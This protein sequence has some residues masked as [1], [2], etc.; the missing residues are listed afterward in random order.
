MSEH[1]MK[2]CKVCY[3]IMGQC[4]CPSKD[5]RIIWDLCED[6]KKDIEKTKNTHNFTII[7]SKPNVDFCMAGD[8]L[9]GAGCNDGTFGVSENVYSVEFDREGNSRKEA[10][11]SAIK[12]IHEANIG[13]KIL[14][15]VYVVDGKVYVC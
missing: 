12:N 3:K 4:R 9:Y 7:I 15:V 5:K 1:F 8:K 11:Y 2:Q 13:V 6:C 10:I 14:A